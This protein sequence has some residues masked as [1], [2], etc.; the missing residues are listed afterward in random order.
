MPPEPGPGDGSEAVPEKNVPTYKVNVLQEGGGTTAIAN[1]DNK[2][3]IER[4]AQNVRAKLSVPR[5]GERNSVE[6][7]V[8][9]DSGSGVTAI[10]EALLAELQHRVPNVQLGKPFDGKARVETATGD[11]R[12]VETVTCPLHLN[13]ESPWGPVRFTMPFIVL[14]GPSKMVIIG[15]KTLR[16]VRKIDVASQFY[17]QLRRMRGKHQVQA[18]SPPLLVTQ[19]HVHL[20]VE[21]FG[22]G[23]G[24]VEEDQTDEVTD[25]LLAQ[26]PR[27]FMEPEEEMQ[28]RKAALVTAVF[29]AERSGLPPDCATRL[30]EL[31][32]DTHRGAFRRALVGEPPA[33]VEPMKVTL[34]PEAR[35]VRAKP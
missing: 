11:V 20:T 9:L 33:A 31:V 28:A 18:A 16:D 27:M 30:R 2:P 14:P 24:P 8:L 29:E 12:N 6:V 10:S 21:A 4:L 35:A 7:E 32:L 15:Q 23:T 13:V 34:K 17:D 19:T 26:G 1:V 5:M 3:H 22:G 25:E